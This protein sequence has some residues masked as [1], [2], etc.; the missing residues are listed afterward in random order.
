MGTRL[1]ELI[2][3]SQEELTTPA[4]IRTHCLG[5]DLALFPKVQIEAQ[6]TDFIRAN[7]DQCLWILDG[8]DEIEQFIS[9]PEQHPKWQDFFRSVFSYQHVI[10]TSRPNVDVDNIAGLPLHFNR[11]L[12]NMGFTNENIETYV[13]KFMGAKEAEHKLQFLKANPNIWG[14]CAYSIKSGFTL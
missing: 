13:K 1:R 2:N 12:E 9:Q 7:K 5:G 10:L 6:I 11:H 3:L 14:H 4:I 8:Y